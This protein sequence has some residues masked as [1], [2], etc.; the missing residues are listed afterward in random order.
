WPHVRASMVRLS[1]G[2]IWLFTGDL[3]HCAADRAHAALHRRRGGIVL[4][5]AAAAQ[6]NQLDR[7]FSC[8]LIPGHR[9]LGQA[10]GPGHGQGLRPRALATH[11][12]FVRGLPGRLGGDGDGTYTTLTHRTTRHGHNYRHPTLKR[13]ATTY[14]PRFSPGGRVMESLNGFTDDVAKAVAT[15]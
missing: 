13:M 8:I 2:A 1:A 7:G 5:A 14:Y 6:G 10:H 4:V 9:C 15:A 12:T 3:A 11:R